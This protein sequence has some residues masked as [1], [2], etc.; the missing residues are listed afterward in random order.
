MISSCTLDEVSHRAFLQLRAAMP[1][2]DALP[3]GDPDAIA[4]LIQEATRAPQKAIQLVAATRMIRAQRGRF[5]LAL[6]ADW[7]MVDALC[8]L[9]RLPGVGPKTAAAT[10]NFS[11]LRKRAFVVDR[12][13]L[14]VCKRLGLLPITAD[15]ERGFRMLMRLMP[16]DWDADD[17]YE[18]HWL[19]K[20]H[21]QGTC[22][23][24]QPSCHSCP[25]ARL[26]PRAA[27]R[28]GARGIMAE[29][30]AQRVSVSKGRA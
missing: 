13:V 10:L 30:L 6:L 20:M 16:P 18:L 7:P 11:T 4:I 29:P 25:L 24:G 12:H 23:H 22:R 21:G 28:T 8:W 19:M 5:D 9:Q 17:L 15:F 14:R 27:L 1:G 3:D 26:C 2:W